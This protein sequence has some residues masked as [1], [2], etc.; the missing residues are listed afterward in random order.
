LHQ[1]ANHPAQ[2]ARD[3]AACARQAE[4]IERWRDEDYGPEVDATIGGFLARHA[5]SGSTG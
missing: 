4:L 5:G 2:V 3:I 1:D